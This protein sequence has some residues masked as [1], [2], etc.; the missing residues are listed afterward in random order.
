MPVHS[1]LRAFRS[2]KPAFGAWLTFPTAHTA[3]Q[4]ILAGRPNGL[5]WVC[6]DCEHGLTSLVPG[7][8]ETVA[9]I[10]S[11]P[12]NTADNDLLLNPSILVRIPAPGIQHS[13]PSTAH[14]IKLALDA[15]AQGIIVP[16]VSNAD[17]ARQIVLDARFPPIGR[18]GFGSPFTHQLWDLSAADYLRTE[19]NDQILVCV[20][21]ENK[22]AIENLEEIA[23]TPGVDVLFIGP[24]DLSLALGYPTP[25]PDPHPEV[26]KVIQKIKQV[27]H[28]NGK[29]V[30]FYCTSGDRAQQ[31]AEQ[32]FDMINVQSDVGSLCDGLVHHLQAATGK[33]VERKEDSY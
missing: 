2:S 1:L 4:V 10:S 9:A 25:D 13:T 7:V 29:K 24:F 17:L 33:K 12:T 6:I 26:E 11:V 19:A 31:R 16:M 30:A 20:Q 32:G 5:S 18:R 14:Q 28:T 23:K 3:R 27:A 15:G 8:A 22:D 21:I